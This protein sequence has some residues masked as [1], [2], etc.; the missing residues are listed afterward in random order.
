MPSQF[1]ETQI[2]PFYADTFSVPL[3]RLTTEEMPPPSDIEVAGKAFHYE[4][5]YPIK[6]QSAVMPAY[7]REQL[8]SGKTPVLIERQNRYYVYLD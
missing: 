6:G 5:S 1:P 8:N 3:I 4:R 7:L 2:E